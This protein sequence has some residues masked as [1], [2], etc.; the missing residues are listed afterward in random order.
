MNPPAD[1]RLIDSDGV[2]VEHDPRAKRIAELEAENETLKAEIE[3]LKAEVLQQ[4]RTASGLRAQISRMTGERIERAKASPLGDRAHRIA[5]MW[6]T[7]CAHERCVVD[8]PRFDATFKALER[9]EKAGR[10]MNDAEAEM[11]KA[12]FGA[13]QFPFQVPFSQ[14]RS[15]RA[16]EKG[17]HGQRKDDL[18][19]IFRHE[20]QI[21]MFTA[22]AQDHG[23][24]MLDAMVRPLVHA[25]GQM[26]EASHDPVSNEV[27]EWWS[28][29]PLECGT[30]T[31]G[32]RLALVFRFDGGR[33]DWV[34]LKCAG[35]CDPSQ[36]RDRLRE[37][38]KEQRHLKA[39]A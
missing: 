8:E 11:V 26:V 18:E 35:G 16:A 22:L 17:K 29:C 15:G 5:A 10:D 34:E 36:I 12:L 7:L 37:M 31:V 13:R 27:T 33:A 1:L 38:V 3:N 2:V 28:P 9:R 23:E 32:L 25:Y 24:R 14:S 39:A 30:A 19:Y 6:Q 20:K 4:V 21:A